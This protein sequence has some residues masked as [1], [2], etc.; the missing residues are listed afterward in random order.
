MK[1]N[2]ITQL[3]LALAALVFVLGLGASFSTSADAQGV[4]R[5]GGSGAGGGASNVGVAETLTTGMANPSSAGKV[6]AYL[7][8]KNDAG[9]WD[10]VLSA[11]TPSGAA[12]T[13]YLSSAATTNATNC[14]NAAAAIYDVSVINTTSTMYY[15]RLYNLAAAPT[16]SS[17]TGFVE[18]IPIPHNSGNGAGVAKSFPI[19]R[20]YSAGLGFCLTANG[21]STDN[22]A[23]ATG[24]YV[25]I[26]Y[27]N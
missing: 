8:S 9:T 18:S 20:Y 2:L 11:S 16:C 15:L 13:C 6:Q 23:A 1:K 14:A 27:K 24:L 7:Y 25:S 4:V 21:S 17:S 26:G 3:L 12:N 22:N 10:P 5:N 19:G